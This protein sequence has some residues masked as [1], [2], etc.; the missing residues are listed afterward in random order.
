M[1]RVGVDAR[2]LGE[3]VTGIG[4]YTSE[5]TRELTTHAAEFF[6]YCPR[7]ITVGEWNQPNVL[8]RTT[9]LSGRMARMLWSQSYLP[10]AVSKD[11]LDVFWGATHR[12]PRLLPSGVARVVTIHDLVWKHAGETMRPLSRWVERRLMPE[13]VRLADRIIADSQST[14]AALEAEYPWARDRIRVV[15]PGVSTMPKPLEK[16]A[17]QGFGITGDYFLF[18]GTLEPRKN[19]RRLLNAYAV[20][21]TSVRRRAQL[22]ITGGKGWGGLDIPAMVEK[23]E[24]QRDVILTG[25]TSDEQLSTLYAH[26][27]FLAMPSLY[28]GF[29]LPLVEAMAH[30]VPALTS[31]RSSLPEVAGDA[32]LLVDPYHDQAIIEGL[33]RLLTEDGLRQALAARAVRNSERFSWQLAANQT[34]EVFAEA[35]AERRSLRHHSR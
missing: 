6:L 11:R 26:A 2:L 20:L 24:L 32:G 35:I 28:E 23:L 13:A 33:T 15:Y 12:L 14:A 3:A 5:L 17:L 10:Y 16:S 19:L 34:M 4:R 25:Y 9:A 27:M 8:Q 18:V 7:P 30:G 22:V 1:I 21:P 31:N 29:G